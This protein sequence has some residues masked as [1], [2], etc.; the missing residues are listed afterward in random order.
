MVE[1]LGNN[2]AP[3]RHGGLYALEQRAQNN[4]RLRQ[5]VVDIIC[6]YLRMPWTPPQEEDRQIR[7]AQRAA[8]TRPRGRAETRAGRDPAEERHVRLTA[9]LNWSRLR[10]WWWRSGPVFWH[11]IHLD[12]GDATLLNFSFNGCRVD[13]ANF[14][15]ASFLGDTYFGFANFDQEATFRWATFNGLTLFVEVE[16]PVYLSGARVMHPAARVPGA[17][18]SGS[19]QRGGIRSGCLKPVGSRP[20]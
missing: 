14:N 13:W 16:G 8:R 7:T 5:T 9:H 17:D 12:L 1:Q 19:L 4:P 2:Q 11:G 18:T 3:V 15:R 6:A 20:C 10:R